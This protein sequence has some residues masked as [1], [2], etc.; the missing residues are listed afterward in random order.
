MGEKDGT[1]PSAYLGLA[2]QVTAI[3]KSS[4]SGFQISAKGSFCLF[5]ECQGSSC[6]N[7]ASGIFFC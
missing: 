6:T 3:V 4:S 2:F 5:V 7:A 1:V